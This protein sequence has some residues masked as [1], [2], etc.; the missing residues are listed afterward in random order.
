M[1]GTNKTP[2]PIYPHLPSIRLSGNELFTLGEQK[3]SFDLLSF[4][5]WS[6]S[7]L[8][9]NATRGRLAEYIV[10]MAL[11][12]TAGVRNEWDAYDLTFNALKV[13]VKASG[14]L[15]SWAQQRLSRPSFSIR[16]TRNWDPLTGLLDKDIRR[17][18]DIYVF[19]L[20]HHLE[21]ATLNPCDLTQWSFYVLPTERLDASQH[22]QK[23][24]RINLPRLLLLQPIHT[25][26]L[27]LR[28]AIL[29]CVPQLT[30]P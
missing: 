29:V 6:S 30:E 25:S 21:K 8:V 16:P 23:A 7:D 19:C 18:A 27:H 17:Q 11:G 1:T 15:Q 5:Q 4:W 14:Y 20:H 3:L 9:S 22:L 12:V 13:E 28:K 24:K 2:E 10:A 26:Y